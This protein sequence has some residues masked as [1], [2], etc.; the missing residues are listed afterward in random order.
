MSRQDKLSPKCADTPPQGGLEDLR[1]QVDLRLHLQE[2]VDVEA[3]QLRTGARRRP[4]KRELCQLAC[5]MYDARRTRNKMLNSQ[6]FGE[7][8][9]DL[10][11]A[12]YCLPARGYILRV[13]ALSYAADLPETTGH[14]WQATLIKEGLIERGPV[15]VPPSK[16]SVRLTPKGRTLLENYLTRLF[17]VSTPTPPHPER[18]GG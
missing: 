5:Q 11:L 13:T 18:A 6:L 8:A 10:L 17:Y 14:R 12:L 15:G 16:H 9:W 4:T 3:E 1:L 2:V 7:P